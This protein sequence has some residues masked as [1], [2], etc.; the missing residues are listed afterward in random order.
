[1]T[2]CPELPGWIV[3]LAGLNTAVT[4]GVITVSVTGLDVLAASTPLPEYVAVML[5]TPV[6][7]KEVCRV[8]LPFVSRATVPRVAVPFEK[9]TCPVGVRPANGV[10]F[11]V[12]VTLSPV[13]PVVVDVVSV[14]VVSNGAGRVVNG[15]FT[16]AVAN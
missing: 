2:S 9:I 5:Y 14:V 8:A 7:A 15:R 1:M 12:K 4:P 6:A 3:K 16:V 11:A 13:P 10:T